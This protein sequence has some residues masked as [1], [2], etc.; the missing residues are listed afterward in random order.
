[1]ISGYT[2]KRKV[3]QK[4]V[5]IPSI[6]I[7]GMYAVIMARLVSKKFWL[8]NHKASPNNMDENNMENRPARNPAINVSADDLPSSGKKR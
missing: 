8:V 7:T 2:F 4:P 5:T 6:I 3:T 1:M